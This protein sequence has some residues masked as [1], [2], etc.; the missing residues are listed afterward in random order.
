VALSKYQI[1]ED[2]RD[3][4]LLERAP[5]PVDT[6]PGAREAKVGHPRRRIWRIF[7]PGLISG[8][9]DE[10]PATIGTYTMVGAQLG[11]AT[12][13]TQLLT[14]PLMAAVQF[15]AAKIG[16]VTGTGLAGVLRRH[17]PKWLLYPVVGGLLVANTLNAGADIGAIAAAINLLVP[18]PI[19]WLIV[20]VTLF[21][22]ALQLRGSYALIA[23]VFKWLTLA[24]LAYIGSGLLAR[25][26]AGE[27]LRGTFLPHLSFDAT[28]LTALVAISGTTFS[29]YLYFWQASQE[30]EEKV[31]MG[32]HRLAQRGGTSNPELKYAAWDVSLGMAAANLVSYFIILATGATLF[33]AGHGDIRSAADAA[34]A[35]RPLAGD[36]AGAL[37][38]IGLIGAGLL[39]VPI[40]TGSAAYALSET[41]D[42]RNGLGQTPRQA[43]AFYAVI[44]ASSGVG[45]LINFMGINPIDALF[46]TSVIF[47]FL[48]PPLLIL[49]LRIAN[50]RAIMG[51]RVNGRALNIL[52]WLAATVASA[53]AIGLVL[54]SMSS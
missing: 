24:L 50:N 38:A 9:S 22:V 29:P 6:S 35:L 25:P 5:P 13:W 1:S 18:I 26:D 54:M 12:L 27:V 37:L 47:G 33:K 39:A 16:L 17:Y 48:T 4:D 7:G 28:F 8:A 14:L 51:E 20:P 11:Y 10:D 43:K 44:A 3:R 34:E 52:G 53:A 23:R 30:V 45:M 15:I 2:A 36:A 19:P 41:F 42:W 46:W 31:A 49:L 32:R 21:I 40:L